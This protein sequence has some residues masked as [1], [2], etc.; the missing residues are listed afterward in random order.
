MLL[1]TR[2]PAMRTITGMPS[3]ISQPS[4]RS[5]GNNRTTKPARDSK[6]DASEDRA[7]IAVVGFS[8]IAIFLLVGAQLLFGT[9][10]VTVVPLF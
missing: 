7:F 3:S 6:I 5:S 2:E 10:G 4:T 1:E 8:L 9:D